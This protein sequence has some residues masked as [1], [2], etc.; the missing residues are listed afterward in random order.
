[1]NIDR[2]KDEEQTP[3][4]YLSN[5]TSLRKVKVLSTYDDIRIFQHGQICIVSYHIRYFI[6][7][8]YIHVFSLSMIYMIPAISQYYN[9]LHH[10]FI[11]FTIHFI[12]LIPPIFN[13]VE[14]EDSIHICILC[15]QA[16]LV[17]FHT[18]KQIMVRVKN[19]N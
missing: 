11:S 10:Y 14:D 16:L 7:M 18:M 13:K 19:E 12:Y 2:V 1:M 17:L 3:S 9:H 4:H 6:F 5:N 8:C 15:K